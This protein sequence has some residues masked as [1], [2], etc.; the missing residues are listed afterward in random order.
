MIE[1]LKD[2]IH[3]LEN[4]TQGKSSPVTKERSKRTKKVAIK[5]PS[6]KF[7]SRAQTNLGSSPISK[8]KDDDDTP[9]IFKRKTPNPE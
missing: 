3:K 2:H 8:E 5:I 1:E 7:A 6:N 9:V 4:S